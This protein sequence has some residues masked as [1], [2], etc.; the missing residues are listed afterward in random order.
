MSRYGGF[1]QAW[2][3]YLVKTKPLP[4]AVCA[5]QYFASMASILYHITP[6]S[7]CTC[8][9][10][11]IYYLAV[12]KDKVPSFYS[13]LQTILPFQIQVF[14]S[15]PHRNSVATIIASASA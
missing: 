11:P 14:C 4:V 15:C 13:R 9:V 6:R 10:P 7:F 8:L 12:Q 3:L 1:P 2:I 5:A